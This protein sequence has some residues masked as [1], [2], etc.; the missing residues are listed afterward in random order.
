[1]TRYKVTSWV[2]SSRE[3]NQLADNIHDL[4]GVWPTI[5]LEVEE[6]GAPYDGPTVSYKAKFSPAEKP[7]EEEITVVL[8]AEDIDA[9]LNPKKEPEA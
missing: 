7:P 5:E 6:T 2:D 3:A 4:N 9:I 8:T 1:M